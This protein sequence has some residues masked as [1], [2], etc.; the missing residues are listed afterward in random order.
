[1]F[2][3]LQSVLKHNTGSLLEGCILCCFLKKEIPLLRDPN[4]LGCDNKWMAVNLSVINVSDGSFLL[5]VAMNPL[6]KLYIEPYRKNY[7][8]D[9]DT[10]NKNVVQYRRECE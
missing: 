10:L 7:Q 2:V 1:M 5:C 8:A 4:E 6:C 3:H 9:T